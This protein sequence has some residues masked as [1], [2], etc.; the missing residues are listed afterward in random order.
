MPST[1]MTIDQLELSPHNVRTH[2]PDMLETGA[3]ERSLLASGQM[4]PLLVHPWKGRK[5][6]WGVFA[7][8]RRW[9][10]FKNLIERGELPRDHPIDVVV[11]DLPDVELTELSLAENLLRRDLRRYEEFA[12]VLKAHR[13]GA[14]P[15]E[16][17][18]AIGQE[19]TWVRG[20]LRLATLAP[21]LLAALET[22][23][24]SLEQAQAFGATEDHALQVA[25]WK[26]LCG[27]GDMLGQHTTGAVIRARL[28]VGDPELQRLLAFVGD[29]TYR[30]AG[31]RFELDLFAG[32]AEQRGRVADETILRDLID[33]KLGEI[34]TAQRQRVG[35][36]VRFQAK[37]PQTTWG[38]TDHALEIAVSEADDGSIELPAGDVVGT[39]AIGA[40]GTADVRWWWASHAAKRGKKPPAEGRATV[41]SPRATHSGPIGV[42]TAI[43][44][45]SYDN[46]RSRADA[47]L[48]E[49]EGLTA[50]GVSI[51]RSIRRSVLRAG[52][53]DAA[54]SGS[55]LGRDYFT[56]AQLRL[57]LTR[58]DAYTADRSE[59]IG[60][61]GL[62][63]A[64]PDGEP[65]R[66]FLDGSEADRSWKEAIAELKA[67]GFIAEIDPA[68]ALTLY[69]QAPQ[70]VK[71]LAEAV[72]AGLGLERSLAADGYR[73]PAH[74][75]LAAHAGVA[76]DASVRRWWRPTAA[77]LELLPIAE[78]RAIAEPFLEP[79]AFA[80]WTK[81]KSAE[82]TPLALRVVEGTAPSTRKA[83][84]QA[85]GEWVHPLLAFAGPNRTPDF[86]VDH[87]ELAEAAE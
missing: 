7:G 18:H 3:I 61:R 63:S 20:A 26:D 35:R 87:P 23:R 77:F 86:T 85:A 62:A 14:S 84:Q 12:A 22:E 54:R 44:G 16:I 53:I 52:L 67:Q 38:S 48:K 6:R 80:G 57:H 74:D 75:E 27:T 8:G 78:R 30:E 40:G 21:P 36:E 32:Q 25:A 72:V 82:L 17:A 64:D 60:M 76:S 34:R 33:V 49:Q 68:K 55:S 37:P 10:S 66:P 79:K 1:T 47:A 4:F 39:I 15:D 45:G 41:A 50:D 13:R 29:E 28:K 73:I 11:R 65:A 81:L 5:D 9:R 83:M 46:A 58:K 24:L 59:H 43:G 51:M 31:G 71:L 19:L 69:R 2:R 70:S 42:G 56:W